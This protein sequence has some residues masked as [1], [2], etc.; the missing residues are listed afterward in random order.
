MKR[1]LRH[2][3]VLLLVSISLFAQSYTAR[4]AFSRGNDDLV[5]FAGDRGKPELRGSADR[6]GGGVLLARGVRSGVYVHLRSGTPGTTRSARVESAGTDFDRARRSR[7]RAQAVEA[8]NTEARIGLAELSLAEGQTAEAADFLESALRL[9]PQHRKALL[10][11]VLVYEQLGD[12]EAATHYLDLA[13]R[14]HRDSAEVHV[15][16]AEY[17]LRRGMATE[18]AREARLAQGLDAGN[19][20][21]TSLRAQAALLLNRYDEALYRLA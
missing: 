21:A 15:L 8:N 11:L 1:K 7:W 16:A 4:E 12:N 20:S 3:V 13:L 18:A 6:T 2:S 9:S 19:R 5:V 17:Y 14:V 10:S